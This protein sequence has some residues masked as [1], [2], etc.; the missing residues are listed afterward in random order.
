MMTNVRIR[1]V[2][3]RV[4][5]CVVPKTRRIL[6]AFGTWLRVLLVWLDLR[7]AAIQARRTGALA[8]RARPSS[9]MGLTSHGLATVATVACVQSQRAQT[10]AHE[11][12][13]FMSVPLVVVVVSL[14][15]VCLCVFTRASA[16]PG[17]A[18]VGFVIVILCIH[19]PHPPVY[20]ILFH[21]QHRCFSIAPFL[22]PSVC[23]AA[24]T[25]CYSSIQDAECRKNTIGTIFWRKQCTNVA[26]IC[27]EFGLDELNTKTCWN[28]TANA[29][30]P[31]RK[32]VKRVLASEEFY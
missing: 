29:A 13:Q 2:L 1:C 27:N 20:S 28:A 30:V 17:Q 22:S 8:L 25:A 3:A 21:H 16:C 23:T 31:V 26:A 12:V 15:F 7:D 11:R 14:V 5:V 24:N 10:G 19:D 18:I 4:C 32:I 6:V 9:P